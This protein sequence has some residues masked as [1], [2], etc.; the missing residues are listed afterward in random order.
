M[1]EI[2]VLETKALAFHY[3][4]FTAIDMQD[5]MQI[6]LDLRVNFRVFQYSIGKEPVFH[7]LTSRSIERG[8]RI[9]INLCSKYNINKPKAKQ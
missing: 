6:A 2:N 9:Q 3:L 5:K 7:Y 4:A 1:T 8:S